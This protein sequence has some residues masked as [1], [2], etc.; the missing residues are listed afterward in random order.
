MSPAPTQLLPL[1]GV[2]TQRQGTG[3]FWKGNEMQR[4]Q[5]AEFGCHTHE[6]QRAALPSWVAEGITCLIQSY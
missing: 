6:G 3:K 1:A 2:S 5:T 4:G